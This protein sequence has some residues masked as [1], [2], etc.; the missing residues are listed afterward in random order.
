MPP[1]PPAPDESQPPPD[2]GF[3]T[4]EVADR[5]LEFVRAVRDSG[6][7]RPADVWAEWPPPGC[8][9][10]EAVGSLAGPLAA[11]ERAMN[12]HRLGVEEFDRM[13]RLRRLAAATHRFPIAD[14]PVFAAMVLA[15]GLVW[16]VRFLHAE[17]VWGGGTWSPRPPFGRPPEGLLDQVGRAAHGLRVR[18]G[19]TFAPVAGFPAPGKVALA[20]AAREAHGVVAAAAEI[21]RNLADRPGALADP[22]FDLF[23]LFDRLEWHCARLPRRGYERCYPDRVWDDGGVSGTCAHAAAVDVRE[24]AFCALGG[25]AWAARAEAV[26]GDWPALGWP[27]PFWTPAARARAAERFPQFNTNRWDAQLEIERHRLVAAAPGRTDRVRCDPADR[28][29]WLDG[30]AVATGLPRT[31]FEFVRLIHHADPEPLSY[32]RMKVLAPCLKGKN[33]TRDLMDKLP[34]RLAALITSGKTGYQLELP[35]PKS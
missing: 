15:A 13:D 6:W 11:W 18:S 25:A 21:R 17:P 35:P 8:I 34:E 32:A 30:R 14:D 28:S 31:V 9:P 4:V 27:F 7:F 24:A 2:F 1:P 33:Q 20:D 12:P 10:W 19:Y 3:D 16:V 22:D 29:V 26:G 5:A 23:H